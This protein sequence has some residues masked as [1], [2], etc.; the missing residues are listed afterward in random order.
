MHR[1]IRP[2]HRVLEIG[3]GTGLLAMM[4][5]RAGASEVITCE[6]RPAVALMAREIIAQNGFSDRIRLIAK[7][8][9]DLEI[10]VDLDRVDVVVWDVLSNNLI[11]AGALPTMEHA[12]RHLAQPGAPV[13]PAS[14]TIRVA[15]AEDR[16][17]DLGRMETVDG[18]DLSPFNWLAGPNYQIP[19]GSD[20]LTLR[21]PP[22]DLFRFDFA[23]GGPFPASRTSAQVVSTGG[24]VNGI[25]QWLT[26]AMDAAETYENQPRPGA[27][28]AFAALFY[29]LPRP[30]ELSPGEM[31]TLCSTHDRLSLDVW[32]E[33]GRPP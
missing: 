7:H 17:F 33:V 19:V 24:R 10:G 29:P 20:R 26:F 3:T 5:A 15:L 1:A 32:A 22:G 13:I 6:T 8:S 30:I 23:S 21:T 4:A 11:G 12:V 31:I 25:V 14:G 28:S 18:F 27:S 16:N 2:G 9:T